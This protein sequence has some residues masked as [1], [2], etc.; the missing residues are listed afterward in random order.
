MHLSHMAPFKVSFKSS[1][2]LEDS[3]LPLSSQW[4]EIFHTEIS[5]PVSIREM[6][7]P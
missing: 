5:K 3:M 2:A 4:S 7:W 6:E 1:P